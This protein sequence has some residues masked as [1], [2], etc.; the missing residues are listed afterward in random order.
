MTDTEA[1]AAYFNQPHVHTAEDGRG[2]RHVFI[3]GALVD[4]VAYADTRLG[5]AVMATQP[6]RVLPGTEYIDQIVVMG[7]VRVEPMFGETA[8][9]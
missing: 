6:V 8:D 2:W 4:H 5:I 3:D 1:E 7:D 9:S